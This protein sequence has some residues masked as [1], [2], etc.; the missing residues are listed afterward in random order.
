M[1]YVEHPLCTA[2]PEGAVVGCELGKL[3]EHG[4]GVFL[5]LCGLTD[6][7]AVSLMYEHN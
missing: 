4:A 1:A 6:C 3:S 5:G 2:L 7:K